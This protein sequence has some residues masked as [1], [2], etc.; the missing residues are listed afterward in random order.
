MYASRLNLQ[1]RTITLDVAPSDTVD[2]VK[3]TIEDREGKSR[4]V[5]SRVAG[6]QRPTRSVGRQMLP[7]YVGLS[8]N[9]GTQEA[10]NRCSFGTSTV[11]VRRQQLSKFLTR[12]TRANRHM[13]GIDGRHHMW[14]APF[15]SQGLVWFLREW[16]YLIHVLCRVLSSMVSSLQGFPPACSAWSS[17]RSSWRTAALSLTTTFS[18]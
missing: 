13:E 15:A 5:E 2:G 12:I 17:P 14:Q 8:G 1:G 11:V 7:N 18:R 10:E 4:C 6:L 3:Q 9:K 16:W